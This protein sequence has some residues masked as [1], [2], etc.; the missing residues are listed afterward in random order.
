MVSSEVVVLLTHSLRAW[1]VSFSF[2]FRWHVPVG[3]GSRQR[4]GG[5]ID[6][7]SFVR[8]LIWQQLSSDVGSIFDY[9]RSSKCKRIN[10]I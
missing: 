7:R 1:E 10:V 8:L 2:W 6:V 4:R 9:N 3:Y 5:I